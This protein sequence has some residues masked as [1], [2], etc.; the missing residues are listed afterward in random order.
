MA[1]STN[2][3][4]AYLGD[5]AAE[6]QQHNRHPTFIEHTGSST[7]TGGS[8]HD[9]D[10]IVR[11]LNGAPHTHIGGLAWDGTGRDCNEVLL[12]SLTM[13]CASAAKQTCPYMPACSLWAHCS[14]APLVHVQHT[15][16]GTEREG[17]GEGRQARSHS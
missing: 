4:N 16:G 8:S 15:V 5:L 3:T 14:A 12:C 6:Q 9:C 7:T 10:P 11:W 1:S 17:K 13:R 2:N